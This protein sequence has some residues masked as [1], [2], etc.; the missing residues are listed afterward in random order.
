MDLDS[1]PRTRKRARPL[2]QQLN[3][4]SPVASTT[5]LSAVKRRKLDI[6]GSSPSTPKALQALKTVIGGVFNFG[7]TKEISNGTEALET[8]SQVSKDTDGATAVFDEFID[9][10]LAEESQ[11]QGVNGNNYDSEPHAAAN[12]QPHKN[13]DKEPRNSR[14][15]Q[16]SRRSGSSI[17]AADSGTAEDID[18]LLVDENHHDNIDGNQYRKKNF[19]PRQ[20]K[21]A[22][23]GETVTPDPKSERKRKRSRTV[24]TAADAE[25][26]EDEL[27]AVAE[28]RASGNSGKAGARAGPVPAETFTKRNRKWHTQPVTTKMASPD[29]A[30]DARETSVS[31][32]PLSGS[33]GRPSRERRRP[34]RYSNEMLEDIKPKLR[35]DTTPTKT[36]DLESISKSSKKPESSSISTPSTK[37]E[38]RSVPT[39]SKKPESESISTPSKKVQSRSISTPSKKPEPRSILTPSKKIR[40]RPRKS[41]TFG[42]E[43]PVPDGQDL[44][45]QDT[46]HGGEMKEASNSAKK[47]RGRPKN[48]MHPGLASADSPSQGK[49][50][51]EDEAGI[52]RNGS[53]R[54]PRQKVYAVTRQKPKPS[55]GRELSVEEVSLIEDEGTPTRRRRLRSPKGKLNTP[56]PEKP[57]GHKRR[58]VS[59]AKTSAP[60]GVDGSNS[61]DITCV[62]C[63]DGDSEARNEILLCDNCDLAAHQV[64]Y[65]VQ[66]IPEGDWLC[67]DCRPDE[68]EELMLVDTGTVSEPSLD[69][70]ASNIPDIEGFEYH[71]Q[72]MQK[73]VLDKLT[74]QRRLKLYGLDKEYRKVHQVV[75][76]T[77]L[78]GEGNSMLVIGARGC[79][80]TAVSQP[81]RIFKTC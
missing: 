8:D 78:A 23:Q 46:P 1:S 65:G 35:A 36:P 5:P 19:E 55:K 3:S 61:D 68:D 67:R 76:Q 30:G 26:V 44:D 21:P 6:N 43:S 70:E 66:V 20:R 69:L 81:D 62:I 13:G 32:E 45:L 72:V 60:E 77:V 42:V 71:M 74:G 33:A 79:G 24:V 4:S 2:H 10:L 28:P 50:H 41:V 16:K 14:P 63:G 40:E 18:E 48:T 38:A 17:N 80:K 75:E 31:E 59:S 49:D 39:Q 56:P 64:C 57:N 47:R 27:S 54:S 7:K 37:P 12:P 52:R 73:L 9:E 58:E 15:R 53:R 25:T 22:E 11:D 29:N 51:T 34:R